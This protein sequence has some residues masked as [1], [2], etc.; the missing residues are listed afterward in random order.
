MPTDI[1]DIC[2]ILRSIVQANALLLPAM[3]KVVIES[4]NLW[5]GSHME[6]SESGRCDDCRRHLLTSLGYNLKKRKKHPCMLTGREGTGDDV[7]AA[8]I[9]PATSKPK[10]LTYIRLSKEDI[11]D[12]RNFLLLAKNVQR[13]F[14][15]QQISFVKESPLSNQLVLKIWDAS[16]AS[17][18]IWPSYSTRGAPQRQSQGLFGYWEGRRLNLGSHTPFKRALSYQAYH[19]YLKNAS[20]DHPVLSEYGRDTQTEY[21]KHMNVIAKDLKDRVIRDMRDEVEDDE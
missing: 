20:V 2:D 8:Q 16:V 19:A 9:I 17:D 5:S 14:D 21:F 11:N 15:A 6:E 10:I 18:P 4:N 7:V 13:A 12:V 3:C 1:T